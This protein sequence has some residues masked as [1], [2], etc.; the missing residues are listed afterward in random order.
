M[1]L[2][3]MRENHDGYF[4][5]FSDRPGAGYGATVRLDSGE[6]CL[7]SIAPA[8]SWVRV[9]K[10]L[11]GF[12]GPLLYSERRADQ[13]ALTAQALSL[14]FPDNLLPSGF[15]T[16]LLCAFANA[17]L[18]C[19][20]SAEVSVT[21]NEAIKRAE[22]QATKDTEVI[23]DYGVLLESDALK[24][25]VFHDV[26]VLPYPKEAILGQ[27]SVRSSVTEC[28]AM[29]ESL[30]TAAMWLPCFQEDIAVHT[31]SEEQFSRHKAESDQLSTRIAAAVRLRKMRWTE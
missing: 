10:S 4:A 31:N 20:S 28:P 22:E 16:P 8:Q 14:L 7:L 1:T 6:P 19:A 12:F 9:K 17:I 18:H 3:N 15:K 24:A 2:G 30:K 21:L 5:L 11:Y 27:S 26:T 23:S 25:S 13:T 29:A